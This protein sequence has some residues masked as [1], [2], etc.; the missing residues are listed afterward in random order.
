MDEGVRRAVG[1]GGLRIE[2]A[3]AAAATN[4]ARVL[5][6]SGRC[7]AIAAGLDADLVVLDADLR[8]VR[9]MARGAWCPPAAEPS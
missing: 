9:V 2:V 1:D 4:P 8:V 3:A 5:G 6:L 7:G